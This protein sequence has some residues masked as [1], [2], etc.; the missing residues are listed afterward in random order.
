MKKIEFVFQENPEV[1]KVYE[2]IEGVFWF[3]MPLLFTIFTLWYH[4][5]V[6]F[7]QKMVK[8]RGIGNEKID[9]KSFEDLTRKSPR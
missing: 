3:P 5:Y 6:G 2:I 1:G 9:F 7:Q 4:L 8:S